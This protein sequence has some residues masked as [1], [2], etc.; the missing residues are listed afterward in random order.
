MCQNIPDESIQISIQKLEE[1]IFSEK[2]K[3]YDPYDALSS[4][5]FNFPL[6]NRIRTIKFISQQIIRRLPINLRPLILIKKGYNP[7]TAGL[8]LQAST[9]LSKALKSKVDYYENNIALFM[10]DLKKMKSKGYSGYCWGYDF[11]WEGR[12]SSIPAYMPTIVATGFVSNALFE[13]YM[14]TNNKEALEICK[15]SVDFIK[16]DINKTYFNGLFCYSYSPRDNQVVFNATMKGARLL[17]QIYSLTKDQN[18]LKE[19]CKTVQFVINNQ[20][21]N[22]SWFYSLGDGRLW[23]DNYHTC[24]ILDSLYTYIK[25]T[26]DRT[27][28]KNLEKGIDFYV[29]NF[30]EKKEIPKYYHN[31]LYPI[32]TTAAAASIITLTRFNYFELAENIIY[33]MIKEM[34]DTSGYFY[35]QNNKRYKNKISYMRWSNAWMYLAM[36]YF[37]YKKEKNL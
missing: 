30:F 19:A 13:N 27:F 10:D 34:Q 3:G 28:E 35:Y 14:L 33:Y 23:I 21:E 6:F 17:A 9:Y 37:I 24:Y 25:L 2:F 5:I 20:Q 22:G 1:Y 11:N 32:D 29:S 36:S 7:V 16:N 31:S 12:L 18:L 26:G 15:S 4:P 8:L